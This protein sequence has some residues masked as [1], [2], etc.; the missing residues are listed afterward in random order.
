[1][2]IG[3]LQHSTKSFEVSE[4][5]TTM[6]VVERAVKAG[7]EARPSQRECHDIAGCRRLS[8]ATLVT[9]S[10]YDASLGRLPGFMNVTDERRLMGEQWHNFS[11]IPYH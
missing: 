6:R 10:V 8:N 11:V 4:I 2:V 7:A 5:Y 9:A 1:M 3:E